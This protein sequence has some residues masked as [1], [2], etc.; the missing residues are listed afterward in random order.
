MVL[1]ALAVPLVAL[2]TIAACRHVR[3]SET[4]EQVPW[5]ALSGEELMLLRRLLRQVQDDRRHNRRD[6]LL[7][8]R[9][10]LQLHG[11]ARW[12][13]ISGRRQR[14]LTRLL[15]TH[16][17]RRLNPSDRR[18]LDR[19]LVII[20]LIR[21]GSAAKLP[22]ARTGRGA[23]LDASSLPPAAGKRRTVRHPRK[24]RHLDTRRFAVARQ[25]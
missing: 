7:A 14:Q 9:L 21:I 19:A 16:A 17:Q 4:S 22:G 25:R 20:D 6:R 1:A 24:P 3:V 23:Q 2:L 18:Q 5:S 12:D 13:A 10:R 15:C 8:R 11:A